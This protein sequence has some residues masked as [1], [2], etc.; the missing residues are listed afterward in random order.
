MSLHFHPHFLLC[1]SP[2]FLC[3]YCKSFP[4]C[5]SLIPFMKVIL[6]LQN[7]LLHNYLWR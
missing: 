7:P 2:L 4:I 1:F 6:K 3:G 5:L